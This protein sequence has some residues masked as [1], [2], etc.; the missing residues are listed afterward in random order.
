MGWPA[1]LLS[2]AHVSPSRHP[3]H[4]R[5]PLLFILT[6]LTHAPPSQV[7]SASDLETSVRGT[8]RSRL[9][10]EA[11]ANPSRA[12]DWNARPTRPSQRG[13]SL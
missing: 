8:W 4:I 7:A 2:F 9:T 6:L 5:P 12:V 1:V 3:S 13:S 11:A 10:V